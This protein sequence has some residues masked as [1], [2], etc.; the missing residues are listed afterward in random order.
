MNFNNFKKNLHFGNDW[1]K[2]DNLDGFHNGF[3]SSYWVKPLSKRGFSCIIVKRQHEYIFY[4]KNNENN[5]FM[6]HL[7]ENRVVFRNF[8][9]ISVDCAYDICERQ[10]DY[11]DQLDKFPTESEIKECIYPFIDEDIYLNDIKYGYSYGDLY[12]SNN[13]ELVQFHRVWP[14]GNFICVVMLEENKVIE[15]QLVDMVNTFKVLIEEVKN[16]DYN[17]KYCNDDRGLLLFLSL[18]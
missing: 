15:S 3:A 11:F 10:L 1:E 14:S 6:D 8:K 17:I 18:K 12:D 13:Y 16:I 9:S 4:L 7:G 5:I 2:Y